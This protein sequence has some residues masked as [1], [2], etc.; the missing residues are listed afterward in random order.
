MSTSVSRRS[1]TLGGIAAALGTSTV[2]TLPMA[3]RAAAQDA[4]AMAGGDF[5]S[6]GLPTLDITVNADGFDGAPPSDLAAGRYLLTATIA[7]GVEFGAAAFMSPPPGMS[8][9]DFLMQAGVGGGGEG[10]GA[11]TP[12]AVPAGSPPATEGGEEE[13]QMLPLFIYRATFA[14][15]TGGP[16]GSSSQVVIDLP[17]GEWILWSDDPAGTQPPV[18]FNVTGDMPADLAEPTA[19]ITM[20]MIDFAINAEGTLTAGDHHVKVQNNGAQPHFLIILK[21]PDTLTNE[22]VGQLLASEISGATPPDMPFNPDTDLMPAGQT[23]TQSIGTTQ[24]VALSLEAGTYLAACFFPTAG[25]GLPHAYHGMHTV[26]TV[27]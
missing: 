9:E 24:W 25:E 27:E 5:S 17:P 10:E 22:L 14:G 26:F 2:L 12:E 8:A 23:A 16:G 15:G 6:L 19:D 1:F 18:I 3:Q 13:A 11:T 20:T 21:G 7:E 4:T